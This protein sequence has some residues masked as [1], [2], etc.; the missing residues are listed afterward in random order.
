M[1]KVDSLKGKIFFTILALIS[2]R[3]GSF[4]PV[5]VVN[6]DQ[7][8]S[9]VEIANKGIFSMFNAFSG[10]SVG[11]VSIFALGMMPY[12]T[13]SIIVQLIVATTPELKK[14]KKE[15]GDKVQEKF[16]QYTKYL[17]VLI[18][19]A[20]GFSLAS[21]LVSVGINDIEPLN[22]K[23]IS[24]MTFVCGTFIL[25]WL[26]NRI[27]IKGIGSGTSLIIFTGIVAE[28]PKDVGNILNLAKNGNITVLALFFVFAVF[29]AITIIVVLFEKSHRLVYIQYPRQV[30]QFMQQ[31]RQTMPNFMPLKINPAGVIPPIFAS[32]IILLPSTIAGIFK[33]SNNV[34]VQFILTNF[35]HGTLTFIILE[36]ALIIFFSFFYNNVVFEPDEIANQLRKSNVFIP[37]TRPGTA[38]AELFKKIMNRLSL[39]GAVYLSLVCSVPELLS[40]TYGYSFMIGGTGLLIVVNVITDTVAAIQTYLLPSRY[41]KTMRK[42]YR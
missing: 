15:G 23:I 31:N 32:S 42:S 11:R 36:I 33:D 14:M 37:G 16:N 17:A 22:F 21:F 2:Y 4:I 25:I 9:F 10:G 41:E 27:S 5:P 26:G 24:A 13:S 18:G 6:I 28:M 3:V 38:T 8:S 34:L 20:Q 7:L 35:T 29:L 40:P 39:I 30:Q 1:S 12:I 19:F